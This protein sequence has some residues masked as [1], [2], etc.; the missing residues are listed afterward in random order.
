MR[1]GLSS[2]WGR[3][4]PGIRHALD[5][6]RKLQARFYAGDY[7]SAVAAASKAE[8]LLPTGSGNF[9]SA[10]YL[11]YDALARAAQYD[12]ASAEERPQ[13]LRPSRLLCQTPSWPSV[14]GRTAGRELAGCLQF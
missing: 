2:T 7:A 14:E 13:Y 10:E 9:E 6:I 4:A 8:P 11:F 12:F 1:A 3:T 5:W